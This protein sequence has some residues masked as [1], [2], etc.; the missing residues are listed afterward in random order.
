MR[1]FSFDQRVRQQCV[2][3]RDEGQR[4]SYG[5]IAA[6][7]GLDRSYRPHLQLVIGA[8][9]RNLLV[10]HR[11]RKPLSSVAAVR[12]DTDLPGWGF[13][14]QAW[15]LSIYQGGDPEKFIEQ[16]WDRFLQEGRT[17]ETALVQ[18]LN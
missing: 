13:L 12:N 10:D 5:D 17:H 14:E 8:L 15:E 1:R 6:S 7:L 2:V 4:C 18:V 11:L 9:K 16:Q 3:A